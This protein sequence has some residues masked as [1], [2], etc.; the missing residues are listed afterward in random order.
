MKRIHPLGRAPVIR[1]G[2]M[3]LA[4]S[5]AIVEYIVQRH[6]GARLAVAS[7]GATLCAISVLAALRRGSLMPLLQIALAL[8]RAGCECDAAWHARAGP[9]A[10]AA[11]VRRRRARHVPYFAGADFTAADVMMTFPFTT[12][13]RFLDYDVRAV[14]RHI[15]AYVKRIEARP[16][17][18]KAM[19]LAGPTRSDAGAGPRL[20]FRAGAR[21][22]I[23]LRGNAASGRA[24]P[25]RGEF[26]RGRTPHHKPASEFALGPG[27]DRVLSARFA[28]PF[29]QIVVAGCVLICTWC[30]VPPKKYV[31]S[32]YSGFAVPGTIAQRCTSCS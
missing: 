24:R 6:G 31:T 32:Q 26:A 15:A 22:T 12:M 25:D 17:Y 1:D 27:R 9:H 11:R 2:D 3:V 30:S 19:A 14:S 23:S 21:L 28:A 7:S 13:R 5:S 18:Q 20:R 29:T 8:S 4:E 16:A 10:T